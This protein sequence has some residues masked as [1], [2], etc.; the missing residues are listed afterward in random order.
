[1]PA[2]RKPNEQHVLEGTSRAD[3]GTDVLIE[4]EGELARK[5]KL[6]EF[7][8][9]LDREAVFT[10]LAA[11]VKQVTGQAA[12]DELMLSLLVDQYEIYCS[13]K[14]DVRARGIMLVGEKGQYVNHS[15]YNLNTSLDKIHKLMREFGMTPATRGAV[16]ASNQMDEDPIKRLMKGI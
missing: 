5:P 6:Q 3:R 11:W 7:A 8:D 9:G 12:V 14:A 15:L 13:A 10:Q 16:K 1:M 2:H 4:I